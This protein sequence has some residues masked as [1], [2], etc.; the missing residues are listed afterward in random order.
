LT[1]TWA[2]R[3]QHAVNVGVKVKGGV[4][5]QVH[6]NV[7]VNVDVNVDVKVYVLH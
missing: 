2:A 7:K 4:Y 1:S 5:V 3:R 6:V